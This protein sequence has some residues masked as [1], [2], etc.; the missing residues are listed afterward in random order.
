MEDRGDEIGPGV[1]DGAA[2]PPNFGVDGEGAQMKMGYFAVLNDKDAESLAPGVI[3]E[4]STRLRFATWNANGL[5][6]TERL[7]IASRKI[8]NRA[9][10]STIGD[11]EVVVIQETHGQREQ[12]NTYIRRL[13]TS[14]KIFYSSDPIA[15]NNAGVAIIMKSQIYKQAFRQE[16]IEIIPGRTLTVRLHMKKMYSDDGLP[17]NK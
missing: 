5:L 16:A 14:H 8:K 10:D 13:K 7:S 1:V 15:P 11:H 2:K 9:F 12:W 4:E 17:S 6:T 3:Q